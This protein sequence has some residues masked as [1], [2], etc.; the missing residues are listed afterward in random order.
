MCEL[1]SD[2]LETFIKK[3]LLYTDGRLKDMRSIEDRCYK[4]ENQ[5]LLTLIETGSQSRGFFC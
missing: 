4:K 2:L 1:Y 5:K 3:R